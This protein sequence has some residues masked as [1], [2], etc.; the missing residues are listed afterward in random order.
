[1]SNIQIDDTA[2]TNGRRRELN[3]LRESFGDRNTRPRFIERH[4]T[5][6]QQQ[7]IDSLTG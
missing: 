3:A 5:Q 4:F 2:S 1:M 6:K 7:G